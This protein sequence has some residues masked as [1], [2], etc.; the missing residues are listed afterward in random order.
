MCGKALAFR[1][2]WF[3]FAALPPR[4]A[5]R[6]CLS[7]LDGYS[8]SRSGEAEP[9]RCEKKK[10]AANRKGG[11]FPHIRRQ[12]RKR[13]DPMK[14]LIK[15]GHVITADDDHHADILIERE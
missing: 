15:N 5:E 7:D 2:G 6:L 10:R 8:D 1:S 3:D 13:I 9:P 14:T 11:G 12:S 4:C